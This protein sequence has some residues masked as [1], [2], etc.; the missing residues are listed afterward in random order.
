MTALV[1]VLCCYNLCHIS[2]LRQYRKTPHFNI[3]CSL[4]VEAPNEMK[5]SFFVSEKTRANVCL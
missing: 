1:H 3:A 5:K 2:R 4:T